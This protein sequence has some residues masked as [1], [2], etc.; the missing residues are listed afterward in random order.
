MDT[1]GNVLII[2]VECPDDSSVISELH[3][4]RGSSNDEEC[5]LHS[6]IIIIII[7]LQ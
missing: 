7:L 4:Y 3:D 5:W 2:H 6:V 1:I